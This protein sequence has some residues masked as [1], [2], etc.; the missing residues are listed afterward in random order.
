MDL[1]IQEKKPPFIKHPYFSS[2]EKQ[3]AEKGF[4]PNELVFDPKQDF[5]ISKQGGQGAGRE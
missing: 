5:F 3:A 4:G 1:F 2:L